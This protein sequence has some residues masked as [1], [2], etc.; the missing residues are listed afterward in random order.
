MHLTAYIDFLKMLSYLQDP[1]KDFDDS[2]YDYM[3]KHKDE[4]DGREIDDLRKHEEGLTSK[5]VEQVVA[6]FMQMHVPENTSKGKGKTASKKD[7][8]PLQKAIKK[9]WPS[10]SIIFKMKN[11]DIDVSRKVMLLLFLLT[12][13]FEVVVPAGANEDDFDVIWGPDDLDFGDGEEDANE[14]MEIRV[15]QIN[16]FLDNYGMKRL[17]P[18]NPFDFLI[19]YALKASYE[20]ETD[21]MSDRIEE[22][23]GILFPEE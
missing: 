12:E 17:D 15:T 11:R 14:R 8:S 13:E 16:L 22:V 20:G 21:Y 2:Y 10:E 1:D 7:F 5:S 3:K 6:E 23:L 4:Y 19:L 9:N 18:G